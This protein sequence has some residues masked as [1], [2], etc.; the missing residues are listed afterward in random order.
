MAY[1]IKKLGRQKCLVKDIRISRDKRSKHR[2][3]TLTLSR[4]VN[5]HAYVPKKYTVS[6]TADTFER[7]M[8]KFFSIEEAAE[9][10][11]EVEQDGKC[12]RLAGLIG[13]TVEAEILQTQNTDAPGYAP[14]VWVGEIYKS[15]DP[16]EKG[17]A[18]PIQ[19]GKQP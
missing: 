5:A 18:N 12:G 9:M 3:V 1:R 17:K 2:T 14:N 7:D 8:G 4:D 15:V 13:Q 10:L 16:C 19:E 6:K 11:Q